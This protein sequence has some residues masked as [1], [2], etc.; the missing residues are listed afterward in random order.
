[1]AENNTT[2]DNPE[3]IGQ[4]RSA[5]GDYRI[6]FVREFIEVLTSSIALIAPAILFLLWIY[7]SQICIFYGLPIFYSS[8]N[9]IR[10][11][12]VIAIIAC[13]ICFYLFGD[14]FTLNPLSLKIIHASQKREKEQEQNTKQTQRSALYKYVFWR[15]F[16]ILFSILSLIVLMLEYFIIV[17]GQYP[18]FY[19]N[20]S[21]PEA[22]FVLVFA[23][24]GSIVFLMLLINMIRQNKKWD[25]S[26]EDISLYA[27]RRF[28]NL[29]LRILPFSQLFPSK[30]LIRL[31]AGCL[32]VSLLAVTSYTALLNSYFKKSYYLLNFDDDQYAIVLDT[33]DYYIGEPIEINQLADRRELLIHTNAYIYLGKAENPMIVHK[34]TFDSVTIMYE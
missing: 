11:L 10:F 25:Q 15:L 17:T 1:M 13:V 2:K 34:E 26:L 33:D 18:R 16:C 27:S 5:K 7:Q 24:V 19:K 3:L 6:K 22:E 20:N 9:I 8:L 4:E 32:F 21:F 12:P 14:Y 23:I 28:K 31:F 29:I 30:K